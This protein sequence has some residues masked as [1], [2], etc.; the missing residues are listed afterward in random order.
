MAHSGTPCKEMRARM[1]GENDKW[2]TGVLN[3]TLKVQII[4]YQSQK[5][6]LN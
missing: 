2:H 5:I 4:F 3:Y 1:P 6:N